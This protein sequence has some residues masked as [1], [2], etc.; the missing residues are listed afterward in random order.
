MQRSTCSERLFDRIPDIGLD[1]VC[2]VCETVARERDGIHCRAD[3]RLDAWQEWCKLAVQG[4]VQSGCPGHV[5]SYTTSSPAVAHVLLK[6]N[7]SLPHDIVQVLFEH[8]V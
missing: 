1:V 7:K 4:V 2:C 6:S 3:C 5:T 8:A